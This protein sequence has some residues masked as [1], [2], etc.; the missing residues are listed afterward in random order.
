MLNL[1][2][3]PE[4]LAPGDYI[5]RFS[6]IG[7]TKYDTE[8]SKLIADDIGVPVERQ[9]VESKNWARKLL[10]RTPKGQYFLQYRQPVFDGQI[11]VV[12]TNF[13]M[14]FFTNFSAH[15]FVPFEEA[16]DGLA[17]LIEEA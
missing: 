9:H 17:L 4:Q 10:F 14:S 8:K 13:A 3:L 12:P 15:T 5:K 1:D 6:V 11:A 16:F 7:D 2:L